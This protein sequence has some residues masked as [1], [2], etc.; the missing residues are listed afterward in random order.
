MMDLRK[1]LVHAVEN[2]ASD[3]HLT[4][5]SPPK[6]RI[7]GELQSIGETMLTPQMTE[8]LCRSILSDQQQQELGRRKELDF[9]FEIEGVSRFRGNIFR[10]RGSFGAVF[11]VIPAKIL[12]F[13]ELGLPE[14]LTR[15]ADSTPGLVLVTGATGSGKST[16]LAA[17]I[18]KINT[19]R[20]E[21]IITMEDPIEFVHPN[22]RSIVNQREVN[23]DTDSFKDALKYALRQDPDV[24]L[25]GEMRDHETIAAALTIAETG[26]LTFGTLHTNS[27]V[28]TVSRIID[29]FP[30][31]QQPQVRTQLAMALKAVASQ[32]LLPHKSGKGRVLAQEILIPNP[33]IRNLIREN[34]IHQIESAMIAGQASS[35]M[36]TMDQHLLRLVLENKISR[37]TA[38]GAA[39][40]PDELEKELLTRMHRA[41]SDQAPHKAPGSPTPTATPKRGGL[42]G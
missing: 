21:H 12:G 3:L 9:S 7:D 29:V 24:V 35:G 28:Q 38:L 34:K 6:A 19:E 4:T 32:T 30:A 40:A 41:S 1:L 33:A 37:Q 10:Q 20:A 26:H 8:Q 27:A 36:Q 42:F 25:V 11:R 31:E 23:S 39:H 13:D 22:K 18:D 14:V 2:G 5:N 17:M 15:V 16:T